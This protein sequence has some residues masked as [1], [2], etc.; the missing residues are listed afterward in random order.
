MASSAHAADLSAVTNPAATRSETDREIASSKRPAAPAVETIQALSGAV[1]L[2]VMGFAF[3]VATSFLGTGTAD[4][5]AV[6][7][8]AAVASA[9]AVLGLA[10]HGAYELLE[11]QG[12]EDL[13]ARI[14][15]GLILGLGLA[16]LA[17]ILLPAVG[18]TPAVLL[19]TGALAAPL[20]LIWRRRLH[21][22]L[23]VKALRP[24]VLILGPRGAPARKIARALATARLGGAEVLGLLA[25][26]AA[27]GT[28]SLDLGADDLGDE[29]EGDAPAGALRTATRPIPVLG[30]LDRLVEIAKREGV[31]EVLVLAGEMSEKDL[32]VADLV[33]LRDHGVRIREGLE[34]YEAVTGRVLVER[35]PDGFLLDAS[36]LEVT[37]RLRAARRVVNAVLAAAALVFIA[38]FLALVAL[39]V[40]VDTRG[41][42]FYRQ[43]RVGRG[44][45]LFKLVKFRTMR[46][47]AEAR[48]GPVWAKAG[49]DRVTRVGRV[50]RRTRIDE[51]P[52]LWNVLAGDMGFVGPRPERP[53]FVDLLR[54]EVPH[55][56]KRH[57]IEPGITGWAQVN[58]RYGASVG[59]A[60]RK[61]EYDLYYIRHASF[62]LDLKVLL[63]TFRVV[64]GAENKN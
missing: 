36:G 56:D 39:A 16:T 14:G 19:G 50:L 31:T 64:L 55:Y 49:D 8:Q 61:L 7:Y 54:R 20:L 63:G 29:A 5:Q 23:R 17:S 4:V 25:P 18:L 3:L 9:L 28:G 46:A 32:P 43:T 24:R 51:L 11:V 57:A 26:D 30:G 1:D 15:L 40:R 62:T 10:A 22:T 12:G 44:G 21:G 33:A 42:I 59:D 34:A 58:Y 27:H 45:R 6:L 52:Q 41:P 37:P 13:L 48:T 60:A 35:L 2:A 53:E 47:D 38:P